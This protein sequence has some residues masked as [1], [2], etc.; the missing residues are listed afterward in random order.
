MAKKGGKAKV[1]IVPVD[2]LRDMLEAIGDSALDSLEEQGMMRLMN[3]LE[4]K[5]VQLCP[6]DS[7]NLES[8][9]HATVRTQGA[10]VKGVL[11]FRAPY[12][13]QVHELPDWARGPKTQA[14]PGNEYGPAGP[15]YLERP[16]RGFQREMAR[17]LADFLQRIWSKPRRRRR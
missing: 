7:G 14:K 15:K 16:L 4:A 1:E 2:Q 13:A 3:V 17:G 6:V 8:S 9:S 12:A 5:A 11:R 10:I